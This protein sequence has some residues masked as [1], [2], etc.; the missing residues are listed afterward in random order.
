MSSRSRVWWAFRTALLVLLMLVALAHALVHEFDYG[1]GRWAFVSQLE[2]FIA[3]QRLRAAMPRTRLDERIVVVAIDE[4]SLAKI[5]RWPWS[6]D[7]LADLTD[8]LFV[9]Q[10]ARVV[11]FDMVFAEP[12]LS[13][14]LATLERLAAESTEIAARLPALRKKFD[15]D[16]RFARAL[17]GRNAVL[18]FF[19]NGD[20]GAQKSGLLPAPAFD[21]ALIGRR[22][23]R[24][25]RWTG[26]AASVDAL[27]N[28][29]PAAGY[30]NHAADPDGIVRSVPLV[31]EYAGF[32]F[33]AL[34]L[35]MYR[36]S[37]GKPALSPGLPP[38]GSLTAA[39]NSLQS[40]VLDWPDGRERH[41]PVG[42]GASVRIPFRGP[43]GP[44]GKSYEYL[45]AS[46]L[47]GGRIDAAHLAGKFVLVGVT[48]TGV[49]DVR[50]T[51]VGE[52]YPGVEVHANM[53]SGLLDGGMPIEPAWAGGFEAVQLLLVAGLLIG[54]LPRIRAARA[55]Q[56]TLVLV[57][58]LIGANLQAYRA[59]G[60]VLPVASALVLGA[61]LYLA[62]TVWGYITEGRN[63]RSLARLFGTYVP[64]QLIDEMS[65][66]PDRYS[67]GGRDLDLTVMFCDIRGFTSISEG[68]TP[69][70]LRTL[71]NLFFS[72]MTAPIHHNRGTLDKYIGDAVMAFWGAPVHDPQH[73]ANAVRAALEMDARRDSLNA[74]LRALGFREVGF[75][76][77]L[78]SGKVNVGDMGSQF[79]RSY[80]VMGDAVNQASRIEGLTKH[81]GVVILVN[82]DT[83]R[84]IQAAQ[85]AGQAP[86]WRWLEVDRVRVKGKNQAVT[87]F[88]PIKAVPGGERAS[89]EETRLWQLALAAYRLQH[90]DEAEAHL[91]SLQ[92]ACP[93][94]S[95][96]TLH[97][98]LDERIERHRRNPPAAAW[99]GAHT[100]E[101]K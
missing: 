30:F 41:I 50:S 68:L 87:L 64:P 59:L 20:P 2:R 58:V 99:D 74:E 32:H 93:D 91:Q 6:R 1:F 84:S 75:G 72:A 83:I 44:Q 56:F 67:M 69:Q 66:D 28:A 51:P 73:A 76:I 25:P 7:R 11:G 39:F 33:E 57:L 79:R 94:S 86:D 78:A 65:R 85:P 45:S 29:A 3:D 80:T 54:L 16:A 38:A 53:L 48:A 96:T 71:I 90:W 88:T 89:D 34:S 77:G 18:G 24:F 14:G 4:K 9:N 42:A 40:V 23:V 13:P 27:S 92:S 15:H 97:R 22:P 35:A 26:Y 82:G 62:F 19:F 52:V 49:F 10:R 81:Y 8:E 63:R 100:F 43:G 61:I 98:Q 21:P 70:R 5:G 31:T 12:D 60:L 36:L 95:F 17:A 46:D 55:A 47:L 37:N 101:T